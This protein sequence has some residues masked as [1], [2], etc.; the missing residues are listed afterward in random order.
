MER[1]FSLLGILAILGGA[2]AF[3]TDRKAVRGRT[4]GW[5]LGLQVLLALFV[6]KTP[7][8]QAIFG[9]LGERISRLLALSYEGSK[10]VFGPLG[11]PRGGSSGLFV[12]AFQV[13][14]TIVF[15]AALFAML[16]HLGV[17]QPIVALF[18]RVMTRLL[19]ASG[20]ESLNAAA[21]VFMGQTEAPLTIRPYLNAMTQS[22]LLCVMTSGMAHISAGIMGAY[23]LVGGVDPR[24]LLASVLMTAP[25][26]ILLAKL[27]LPETGAPQTAGS[28]KYEVERSDANLVGAAARG[29]S[30]GL[31]LAINV[32]AML[33]SFLA[34]IALVNLLLGSVGLTLEGLL[35]YAFAPVALLMG[36]P[37]QDIRAVGSLLGTRMVANEFIAYSAL[38]PLK[39]TLDP[40]S[41]VIATF[42]L[43]GFANFGS[44]GIQIGGIGALMP[45]RKHDL[46][47]LGLRAL[48][49]GTLANFLT[50]CIAGALL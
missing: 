17:M 27:L 25:G 18:A 30:E 4:V 45:E 20:A 24:Y 10:F 41:F 23:I 50:A 44:I 35:G 32:A 36:V 31:Q 13:L 8:G 1:L 6:L 28:V 3:S 43:C 47:R 37:S 2:Y 19:G 40:R 21:G 11:E 33:I 34:L 12:F 29:T 39:T 46:A 26:S 15:V 5:G 14:P 9:W 49:A 7:L 38:G 48:I 16:Y 42:A 22:E